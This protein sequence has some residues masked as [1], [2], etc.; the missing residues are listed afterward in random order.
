M[1]SQIRLLLAA[2]LLLSTANA[3][4]EPLVFRGGTTLVEFTV[5]A[6]DGKGNPITD[7]KPDE[8]AI[9]EKDVI[10]R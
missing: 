6:L 1:S 5:I 3:Q 9:R 2:S 8:I 7:L 10:G 4:E